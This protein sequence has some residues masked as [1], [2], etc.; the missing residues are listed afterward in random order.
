MLSILPL[1]D[2]LILL[3]TL[4]LVVGFVVKV[5]HITTV[6]SPT[7]LGFTS[8]DFALLAAICMGFAL[9]L[10]ARS[11]LR[12]NEPRLMEMER[13][14]KVADAKRRAKEIQENEHAATVAAENGEGTALGGDARQAGSR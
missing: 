5:I 11:W 12:V 7:P 13:A 10:V 4:S 14:N 3:G 1:V 6:Y 9:T 2:A 8:V